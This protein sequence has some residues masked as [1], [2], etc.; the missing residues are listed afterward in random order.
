[1]KIVD[2]RI[3]TRLEE[4]LTT[5]RDLG[6]AGFPLAGATSLVFMAGAEPRTAVDINRLGLEGLRRQNGCFHLGATLRIAALQKHHEPGWVLDRVAVQ[7]ASQQIRNMSTLGGNICQVWSWCDFPV[8]LLALEA[9][10]VIRGT[11]ERALAAAEF[12]ESQPRRLFQPGDLLTEIRVPA[13]SPGSGFGYRKQRQVF[14]GFSLL[15]LAAR[16]DFEGPIIRAARVAIGSAVPFPQRLGDV[17]RALEGQKA[18]EQRLRQIARESLP[19]L[20]FKSTAGLSAEYLAHLT[21]V[22]LGDVLIEAA[23]AAGGPPS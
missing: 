18:K 23:S 14:G 7:L 17:E 10:M 5:L 4:A 22:T 8:A 12:F 20:K 6:P 16:L 3:P 9:T 15:T 21:G 19:P 1:M 11:E 13:L 2:Y